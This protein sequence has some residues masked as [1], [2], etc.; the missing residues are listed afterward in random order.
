MD[1]LKRLE[2]PPSWPIVEDLRFSEHSK[3][4]VK[5][6]VTELLGSLPRHHKGVPLLVQNT[7]SVSLA[8]PILLSIF[9]LS[10]MIPKVFPCKQRISTQIIFEYRILPL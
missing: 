5:G 2:T 7:L 6:E 1:S 9:S 10:E 3:E 4:S 8:L